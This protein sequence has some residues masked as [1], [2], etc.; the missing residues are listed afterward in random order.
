MHTMCAI[1][2]V[3]FYSATSATEELCKTYGEEERKFNEYVENMFM[4]V[5]CS[6]CIVMK[7]FCINKYSL[8]ASNVL[9]FPSYFI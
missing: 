2:C 7:C 3:E 8:C 4:G 6:N 9:I 1:L 5:P